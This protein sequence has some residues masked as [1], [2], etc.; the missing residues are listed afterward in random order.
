[1]GYVHVESRFVRTSPPPTCEKQSQ[2]NAWPKYESDSDD[3]VENDAPWLLWVESVMVG[4]SRGG[5]DE[6][7]CSWCCPMMVIIVTGVALT[8]A[9][10][11]AAVTNSEQQQF[12]SVRMHGRSSRRVACHSSKP[13]PVIRPKYKLLHFV[14]E[15]THQLWNVIARN[16]NDRFWR[17]L[18]KIF[19]Y[20]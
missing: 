1:M 2:L 18:A 19:I 8:T 10:A 7:I 9:A 4:V 13:V 12:N 5:L 15:K 16:Y 17:H 6:I 20:W 11:A 14:S 3:C